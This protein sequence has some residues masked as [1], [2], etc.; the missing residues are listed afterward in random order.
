MTWDNGQGARDSTEKHRDEMFRNALCLCTNFCFV[1]RGERV[2]QPHHVTSER[3]L[4]PLGVYRTRFFSGLVW[5]WMP[6][7]SLHSLLY[8]VY[9][10]YHC[11]YNLAL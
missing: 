10:V 5:E 6:E 4:V 3:L 2:K 8:E 9:K 1:V 7:G 11:V